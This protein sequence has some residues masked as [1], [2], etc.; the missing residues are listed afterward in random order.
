MAPRLVGVLPARA[1]HVI[2]GWLGGMRETPSWYGKI[3]VAK[4]KNHPY[5][6][7]ASP[8]EA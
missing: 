4:P 2:N 5:Q 3:L 6:R 1:E 7:R 8:S